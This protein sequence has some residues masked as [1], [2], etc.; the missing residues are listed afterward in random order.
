MKTIFNSKKVEYVSLC[1]DNT[2]HEC[3]KKYDIYDFITSNFEGDIRY[4]DIHLLMKYMLKY[5]ILFNDKLYEPETHEHNELMKS[6]CMNKM[7]LNTICL[8]DLNIYKD[9]E[10]VLLKK[11]P[12]VVFCLNMVGSK[13]CCTQI[14]SYH[15]N[16]GGDLLDTC[17][18]TIGFGYFNMVED[19]DTSD[20][21]YNLEVY[22]AGK[23]ILD[24]VLIEKEMTI[25]DI[26]SFKVDLPIVFDGMIYTNQLAD[27]L[28][29]DII[30][31]INI[32]IDDLK[33]YIMRHVSD[34][35]IYLV[36]STYEMAA[37][38]TLERALMS[39]NGPLIKGYFISTYGVYK[40]IKYKE[41]DNKVSE[42]ETHEVSKSED[43]YYF[44]DSKELYHEILE[45]GKF[46][47][48]NSGMFHDFLNSTV[49]DSKSDDMY[50]FIEN[51]SKV[52][53]VPSDQFISYIKNESGK[54]C[55]SR[56]YRDEYILTTLNE[57][58]TYFI[59]H[60][61]RTNID[62]ILNQFDT[63][64]ELHKLLD[65]LKNEVNGYSPDATYAITIKSKECESHKLYI[66]YSNLSDIYMVY[67][68]TN[69]PI[70]RSSNEKAIDITNI[71]KKDYVMLG[72]I[73][74]EDNGI[75]FK[76]LNPITETFDKLKPQMIKL[77]DENQVYIAD[78]SL[79]TVTAEKLIMYA[80]NFPGK[81]FTS[82]ELTIKN[83]FYGKTKD[84]TIMIILKAILETAEENGIKFK[85]MIFDDRRFCV[86]YLLGD[87][88][89]SKLLDSYEKFDDKT[90][91]SA[92]TGTICN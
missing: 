74:C 70:S 22:S 76:S 35:T 8:M 5:P 48:F 83:S 26:L 41:S 11:N 50:S 6:I 12:Y 18:T 45:S 46:P 31:K 7:D 71:D 65:D 53:K 59:N 57:W 21:I 36:M 90:M 28:L 32:K 56:S 62:D 37:Q 68:M 88:N 34:K 1:K 86:K 78:F 19:K 27:S 72:Y 47:G 87:F 61:V 9:I 23:S 80:L 43:I 40:V 20:S 66:T 64:E 77:G 13:S 33:F 17:D 69:I 91:V 42:K 44:E 30:K 25:Y 89:I 67:D 75:L 54:S 16:I 14:L 73:S 39:T 58:F 81:C 4:R 85:Y 55:I 10:T 3:L 84:E 92:I 38:K 49:F 63:P 51:I 15:R 60:V 52:L 79:E 82:S 2:M 29:F 24:G